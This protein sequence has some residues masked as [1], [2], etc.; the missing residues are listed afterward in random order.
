MKILTQDFVSLTCVVLAIMNY[1]P[2]ANAD[3]K[4]HPETDTFSIHVSSFK[5]QSSADKEKHRLLSRYS[6]VYVLHEKVKGRG[7]WYRVYMGKY[8]VRIKAVTAARE[9]K[10]QG[11][12]SYT[13]VKKIELP[14]DMSAAQERGAKLASAKVTA[15]LH[16]NTSA[17]LDPKTPNS[18]KPRLSINESPKIAVSHDL[19]SEITSK[20]VSA[21][22]KFPSIVSKRVSSDVSVNKTPL[23]NVPQNVTTD[24][25]NAGVAKEQ[26]KPTGKKHG[27]S[28]TGYRYPISRYSLGIKVGVYFASSANA[29]T[30]SKTSG[31]NTQVW[32]FEQIQTINSYSLS[33]R[34]NHKVSWLGR[35]DQ[36]LLADIGLS[37]F[38]FGAGYNMNSFSLVSSY[39]RGG[40]L[41]SNIKGDGMP[42]DFGMGMGAEVGVG[43]VS[44]FTDYIVGF[45]V[46]YSTLSYDYNKPGD[47]TVSATSTSL[48]FSGVAISAVL[49]YSFE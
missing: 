14:S 2:I 13:A 49:R 38:S 34:Y 12:I 29:F 42:G 48:D 18:M 39:V 30:V 1:F 23:K 33:Y 10:K 40:V 35:F 22:E 44:R 17:T 41:L 43:I 8:S 36:A 21:M 5:T 32:Q 15:P 4:S 26:A 16:K 20:P 28:L 6:P 27:Y 24:T 19:E 25:S 37:Q 47:T 7:M 46:L 45:E 31:G 9:Y 3:S 11:L